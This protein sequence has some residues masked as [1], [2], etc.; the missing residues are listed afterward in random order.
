MGSLGN[1]NLRSK[2][3]FFFFLS[4]LSPPV[5]HFLGVLTVEVFHQCHDGER[6]NAITRDDKGI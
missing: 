1:V 2:G 3:L 4:H 5:K 6:L